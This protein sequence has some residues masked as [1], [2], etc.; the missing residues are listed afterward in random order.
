MVVTF[1]IPGPLRPFTGG[2]RSVEL[3]TSA[4][5]LREALEALYSHHPGIHDRVLTEQGHIREHV[6]VFVGNEHVRY[7]G[8]L[9]TPLPE[10][11]AEITIVA[12]VSGG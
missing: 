2:R 4:A 12:A 8:G 5:T 10:G 3:E 6:N 7:T 1:H 11:G 9:A